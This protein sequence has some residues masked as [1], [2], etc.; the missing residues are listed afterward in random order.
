MLE[1]GDAVVVF[2]VCLEQVGGDQAGGV[3]NL[4]RVAVV[5]LQDGGAP[6]GLNAHASER[7][8]GIELLL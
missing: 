8:I 4:P 7:V 3:K 2:V 5:D 1:Q 6:V